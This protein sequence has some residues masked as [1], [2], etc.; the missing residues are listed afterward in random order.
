MSD[1]I[2]D[3]RGCTVT[4]GKMSFQIPTDEPVTDADVI[5]H[6]E[7]ICDIEKA[8]APHRRL[9]KTAD[10]IAKLLRKD[11][12]KTFTVRDDRVT[13]DAPLF[14]IGAHAEEPSRLEDASTIRR[15][16][17][18]TAAAGWQRQIAAFAAEGASIGDIEAWV[19]QQA[20]EAP[21]TVNV[22]DM[23]VCLM[24]G[25]LTPGICR[26]DYANTKSK[27]DSGPKKVY[28][29]LHD[30]RSTAQLIVDA[31]DIPSPMGAEIKR[32]ADKSKLRRRA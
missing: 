16:L 6:E 13:E 27:V 5:A 28:A 4:I 14:G 17:K 26:V 3:Y 15:I 20:S 25:T 7:L 10:K 12:D 8:A 21:F 30:V 2:D 23:E 22:G 11:V 19:R 32:D 29:V 31:Y 18:G 1:E 9:V 24:G